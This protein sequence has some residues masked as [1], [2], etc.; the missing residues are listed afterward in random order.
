MERTR[1]GISTAHIDRWRMSLRASIVRGSPPADTV[2]VSPPRRL[3]LSAL[4]KRR[5]YRAL[6][7]TLRFSRN[8]LATLRRYVQSGGRYPWT[9]HVRTPLGWATL[10]IPHEHDV[11]TLNEVFFRQDYGDT[12][13]RVVVDI[14]ANIGLT[15]LYFLSR[16]PDSKVYA[17]E[18]VP[19]NVEVLRRNVAVFE[20]RC[21]VHT[22]ALAPAAGEAEFITEQI[23]RY[24]GLAAYSARQGGVRETVQCEAIGAALRAVLAEEGRID[25]VKIDTEGSEEALVASIPDD[26]WPHLGTVMY[27]HNGEVLHAVHH[28]ARLGSPGRS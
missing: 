20:D 28:R 4:L 26:V 2:E 10:H 18:P 5:N 23:G 13:P 22:A 7:G 15:S 14:G 3:N 9:A 1:R 21:V 27:E 16:R 24:S 25:L 12:S 8:P 17:W 11:R 6:W 19:A